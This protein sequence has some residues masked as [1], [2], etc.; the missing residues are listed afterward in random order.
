M[1]YLRL[2]IPFIKDII[3]SNKKSY[4]YLLYLQLWEVSRN[5]AGKFSIQDVEKSTGLSYKSSLKNIN[6]LIKYGWIVKKGEYYTRTSQLLLIPFSKKNKVYISSVEEISKFS[7]KN[8]AS[9]RAFLSE[10]LIQHNR[11]TIKGLA[12]KKKRIEGRVVTTKHLQYF[13]LSYSKCLI[14]KSIS[15]CS[16]YRKLQDKSS[17]THKISKIEKFKG[18][19]IPEIGQLIFINKRYYFSYPSIRDS[20]IILKSSRS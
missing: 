15:T 5:R 12:K 4:S 11:N 2:Y 6:T 18:K 1:N 3:S 14:G 17:Y 20:K 8:I 10:I 7:W 16:R 19:D 9:F 13:S